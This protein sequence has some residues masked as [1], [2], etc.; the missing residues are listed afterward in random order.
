MCLVT[1]RTSKASKEKAVL[2]RADQRMLVK[3]V[4]GVFKLCAI[5]QKRMRELV[6]GARL[7]Y[8]VA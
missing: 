1:D 6:M 7:T 8:I 5:I 3:E 2:E 4:G